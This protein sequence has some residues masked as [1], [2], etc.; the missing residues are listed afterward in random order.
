LAHIDSERRIMN[1]EPITEA[2]VDEELISEAEAAHVVDVAPATLK[3][4]RLGR[5]PQN[6]LRELPHIRIGRL[7]KYRRSDVLDFIEARMVRRG[8]A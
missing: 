6:P 2:A 4:A 1:H 3:A 8:A 7:V 5:L